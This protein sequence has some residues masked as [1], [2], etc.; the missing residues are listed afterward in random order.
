MVMTKAHAIIIEDNVQNSTVLM[1]LLSQ[2]GVSATQVSDS[3]KLD[4]ALQSVKGADVVFLDLEMP[5]KNGYEVFEALK[6]DTR[7]QSIPIVAYTVHVS[8]IN[9]AHKLGFHSFLGKP[10]DSDRFPDQL[11]RILSGEPVW[12]R[13]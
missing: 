2:S 1:K 12:D 10:L 8:E 4:S 11:A 3:N 9:E 6:A 5:G 13:G 7:F